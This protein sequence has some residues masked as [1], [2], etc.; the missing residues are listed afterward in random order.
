MPTQ[1]EFKVGET[2][3]FYSYN[4]TYQPLTYIW[5]DR[6]FCDL[7]D[8]DKGYHLVGVHKDGVRVTNTPKISTDETPV[9]Q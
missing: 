7:I 5:N 2:I 3:S 4:S 6:L 9:P 8:D 1:D